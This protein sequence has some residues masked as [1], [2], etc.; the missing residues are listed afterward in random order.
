MLDFTSSLYLGFQHPSTSVP[1]WEALTLG[2]PAALQ[3]PPGAA[4]V[5]A[6]LADLQGCEA[7][8]LLPSTLHLFFDLFGVLGRHDTTIYIEATTYAMASWGV[9]RGA[10][11]GT[12]VQTFPFGDAAEL[13]RRIARATS[14]RRRPLIVCDAVRPGS[15]RQPPLARYAA[16]ATR[17]G[18]LLVLDDTQGLGVLGHGDPHGR[19]G[20][21][22]GGGSLRHHGLGGPRIIVGA[23][24]AKGFGVPMAALSGSRAMVQLF[25]ERSQTRVHSSPPSVAVIHAARHALALNRRCGDALRLRLLQ[26]V[27]QFRERIARLSLSSTGSEF[28]VQSLV[29]ARGVD[30]AALHAGLLQRRVRAVL[31]RNAGTGDSR[32]SFIFT[33]AHTT[34]CIDRAVDA[35]AQ[36]LRTLQSRAVTGA[37]PSLETS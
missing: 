35:L 15:D 13:E 31:Q 12:P 33:A 21:T 23:S 7:S 17:H 27:R 24:L 5:S 28:P 36:T 25:E 11:T 32:L 29:A 4:E 30:A 9:Q 22:G 20:N 3:A 16:L 18:G 1:P 37:T 14:R 34:D 2:R 6:Q 19:A 10:S 26:R 8:T